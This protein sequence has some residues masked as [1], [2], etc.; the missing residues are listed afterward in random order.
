[1]V[2]SPTRPSVAATRNSNHEY[3]T[4]D[5]ASR[6]VKIAGITPH[7]DSRWMTQIAR[8]LTD[9]NDGFLRGKRY[10]SKAGPRDPREWKGSAKAEF[11]CAFRSPTFGS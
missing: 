7:P 3:P 5:I 4:I 11:W 6:G 8:N 10:K 9:L 1:L 2:L